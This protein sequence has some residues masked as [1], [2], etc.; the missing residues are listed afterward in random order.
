MYVPA[1]VLA[2]AVLEDALRR[3]CQRQSPLISTVKLD[4]DLKTLDP[5]TQFSCTD[6]EPM[7]VGIK[8]LIA[9]YL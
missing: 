4:G 6:V 5:F 8:T 9:D 7:I 2:G 3:L 1:A